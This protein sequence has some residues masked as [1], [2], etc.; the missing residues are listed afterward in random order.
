MKREAVIMPVLSDTMETG[1]LSSW[2]KQVG[3]KVKKGDVLAE[4]ESDKAIMDVEAFTDGYLAAPLAQAGTD[5]PV[6]AEIG[7]IVDSPEAANASPAGSGDS[8]ATTDATDTTTATARDTESDSSQSQDANPDSA[9]VGTDMQ[10]VITPQ[11]TP[12]SSATATA[13]QTNNNN[14]QHPKISPYARGLARELGIDPAT[15]NPGNDGV[16]R[17]AQVIKSILQGASPDLNA[18]PE[19]H[20]KLLTPMHRAIAENMSA[21]VSTPTF[22]VS[23]DISLK[24]LHDFQLEQPYSL[25]LL[26]SR[27]LAIS[28]EKHPQ[29]NAAYTPN[30]LAVRKQVDVGIAMDIPGGLVTPVIRD[31]AKRPLDEMAEDWDILKRKAK[32]QRLA[33]ADYQG[34]T[35]YLSNLG[36]FN[37]VK[38]FEAVVPLGSAAIL[39]VGAAQDNISR[40][41]LSCDHRVVFG[42]DAARFIETFTNLLAN[43][44]DLTQV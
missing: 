17:S 16:I 36:M 18:G 22:R 32:S 14:Q 20:Y 35:V 43:P 11:T 26:L 2:K 10:E 19:W 7:Y 33:P 29:F 6:G 31:A 1:H 9:I 4:V 27:A 41:T 39:A 5:I 24:H 44:E 28:V 34:A 30:G 13:A 12:V 25:S 40:F 23:S 38:S 3:D 42:A 15:I 21:T 37:W 8:V